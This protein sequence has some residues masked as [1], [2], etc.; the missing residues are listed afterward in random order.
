MYCGSWS[1]ESSEPRATRT[2]TPRRACNGDLTVTLDAPR[3]T[4]LNGATHLADYVRCGGARSTS[5][6]VTDHSDAGYAPLDTRTSATRIPSSAGNYVRSTCVADLSLRTGN[7]GSSCMPCSLRRDTT[8]SSP[9]RFARGWHHHL[10]H[11]LT[12]RLT[13]CLTSSPRHCQACCPLICHSYHHHRRH[14]PG[15]SQ[16]H[17]LCIDRRTHTR[18]ITTAQPNTHTRPARRFCPGLHVASK[19]HVTTSACHHRKPDRLS[20]KQRCTGTDLAQ[21]RPSNS[22]PDATHCID[23]T[24]LTDLGVD[25]A[26]NWPTSVVKDCV[27][28]SAH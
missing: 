20:D 6:A 5:P 1:A 2:V 13:S 10:T 27:R 12:H 19:R 9:Q 24:V 3:S 7:T 15:L 4:P 14:H 11:H 8:T 28:C 22:L 18:L 26:R 23:V 16:C 21:R 25:T 17:S